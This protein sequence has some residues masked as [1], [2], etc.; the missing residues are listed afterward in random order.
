MKRLL[1]AIIGVV[2]VTLIYVTGKLFLEHRSLAEASAQ[3]QSHL[4]SLKAD[5]QNLKDD[6]A[7]YSN[8]ENLEKYLRSQFNYKNPGEKLIIAVPQKDAG[9]ASTTVTQ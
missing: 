2:T 1:F 9:P 4:D 7:Y 8:P 6:F 5:S 3:A